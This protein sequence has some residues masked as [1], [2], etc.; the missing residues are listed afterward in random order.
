MNKTP[1]LRF[2]EFSGEWEEK[3]IGEIF[4]F[5]TTNSFSRDCLNDITGKVK[6]IHYGDIHMKFPTILDVKRFHIPYINEDINIEKISP[7]SYC[8]E[9]DVVIADASEDYA[10][11][12]KSVEI[13][14]ISDEKIVAGLHTI[15]VRDNK[16]ITENGFRGYM[17]LN[18]RVRKQ[19]KILA[20]GSKVLGISKPNMAQVSVNIPESKEQEKLA[21]FFSLVDEKIQKQQKKVE[22]LEEYKKGM[23]QKIFS[24]EIR[25]KKENEEEY[26]EWEFKKL[27][28]Y[29]EKITKKNKGFIVTNVISNSAKNGLISQR[30]FFDK[31]IA[32]EDSIDGYYVIEPGDFVYNPRKSAESPYGP[33]NKYDLSE[34]GVVSPLYLC[35][36]AN[37][38][39]NGGFLAFY[40][41]SDKWYRFIYLN[42]DQGARHDRV[43]IKDSVVFDLDIEI[44][45][46]EEQEK[47]VD[48]LSGLDTKFEK[49]QQKLEALNQWKRGLLQQMFV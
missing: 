16:G 46:L 32:N 42:S 44:P 39:I 33:I 31:D 19:I 15:L 36:R 18:E 14:N 17:L 1:K 23:M 38:K 27:G 4:D 48:F 12:G 7:E 45:T 40:F 29:A 11:I 21:S 30:N 22:A 5:Y 2:P 3:S 41:K 6:N 20:V 35:F 24:R 34:P 26:P 25:F 9:G 28:D 10:D 8:K 49:E 37:Y 47:I 13:K 43:S